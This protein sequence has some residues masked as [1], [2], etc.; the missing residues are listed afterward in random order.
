MKKTIFAITVVV[1]I[2]ILAAFVATPAFAAETVRGGPGGGGGG[3]GRGGSGGGNGSQGSTGT[4]TGVP[5]EQNIN[6]DGILSEWIETNLA[7]AL[8]ISPEELTARLDAGE[9]FSEIAL[10]LGFDSTVISDM[11]TQARLDALAQAVAEGLITQEQAD[12]LASRGSTTSGTGYGNG[13]GTGTGICD[14]D[15]DGDGIPD[16]TSSMQAAKKSQHKGYGK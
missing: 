1:T 10:S 4:G 2:A 6:L 14:G 16:G 9:T 11:L 8:G 3:G 13:A 12:W 15:C 5:V 7:A